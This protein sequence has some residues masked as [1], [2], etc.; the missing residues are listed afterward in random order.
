MEGYAK[1]MTSSG[2]QYHWN[3]SNEAFI[4]VTLVYIWFYITIS[5]LNSM[6]TGRVLVIRFT[7]PNFLLDNQIFNLF[8]S[9]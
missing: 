5:Q 2:V 7:S 1:Q 4:L 9:S 3:W 6:C 8:P